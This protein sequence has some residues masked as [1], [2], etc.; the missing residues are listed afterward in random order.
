MLGGFAGEVTA[1][2]SDCPQRSRGDAALEIPAVVDPQLA[3]SGHDRMCGHAGEPFTEVFGGGDDQ[4]LELTLGIAGGFDG[5]GAHGDQHRQC[6]ALAS[7]AGLGEVFAGECFAS[8]A[9]G[10][11]RI[12][13]GALSTGRTVWPV[14]F[15]HDFAS[16]GEVS[17][18]ACAVAAGAFDRPHSQCRVLIGHCD[19]LGVAGLV[20]RRVWWSSSAPVAARTTAAVWVCL[21][22]STPMTTSTDSDNMVTA[23]LLFRKGR[24]VPVRFGV[25]QD[26][27][28]TRQ[29]QPGG[30]APDQASS[31]SRAGAGR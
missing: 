2:S 4:R 5:H 13:L 14:E 1:A 3:G 16:L 25:R 19:Q 24:G 18:E 28:G 23:F 29:M 27:D 15:D 11:E 8:G 20:R 21:W 7:T 30:Q 17:G 6:G 10:V 22:V 12:G 26:C 31:S 9:H